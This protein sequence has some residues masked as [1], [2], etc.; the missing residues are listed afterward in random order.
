[1]KYGKPP[2]SDSTP[3]TFWSLLDLD[4]PLSELRGVSM[5]VVGEDRTTT[6][7]AT[8]R[9]TNEDRFDSV[10]HP[11]NEV[12]LA[13]YSLTTARVSAPNTLNSVPFPLDTA[14]GTA[15]RHLRITNLSAIVIPT[16]HWARRATPFTME[17]TRILT[18]GDL[19]LDAATIVDYALARVAGERPDPPT[20]EDR[21]RASLVA[22]AEA[23]LTEYGQLLSDIVYRIENSALFDGSVPTTAA[24][25]VAMVRYQTDA[26]VLSTQDLAELAQELEISYSVAKANAETLGLSHLPHT[27]QDDGRRAAKAARLASAASNEAEREAALAQ[28]ARILTGLGL[29]YLP[30]ARSTRELTSGPAGH[31]QQDPRR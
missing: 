24:F 26:D 30:D 3:T 28:V 15:L 14:L 29:H 25:D 4:T 21:R 6:A 31:Q 2:K 12:P 8:I 1:M 19:H 23:V 11:R 27:A 18:A 9:I 17:P 20:S 7:L 13:A 22:N 16:I 5:L 10:M